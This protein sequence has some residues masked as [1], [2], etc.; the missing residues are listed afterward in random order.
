MSKSRILECIKNSVDEK[1]SKD[2]ISYEFVDKKEF[3]GFTNNKLFRFIKLVF[4]NSYSMNKIVRSIKSGINV[5][6]N[7]VFF[8]LYESNIT[9]FIRYIHS[10]NVQ[11]CGWVTLKPTYKVND[12]KTTCTIDADINQDDLI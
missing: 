1:V 12:K 9:P 10:K 7:K 11:A 2:L 6:G 8:K 5:N 3:Y 4:N